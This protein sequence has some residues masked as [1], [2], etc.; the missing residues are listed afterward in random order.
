MDPQ[1]HH[2]RLGPGGPDRRALRRPR[3]P[4]AAAHRRRRGR[5]SA[6]ADDAGRELPGLSRRHHGPGSDGRD[7][8]AGGE[9]RRRDHPGQRHERRPLR[10]AD[11]RQ[12][13]RGRVHGADADHR[14]RRVGAAARP[15]VG[16]DADGPRR[17]DLRDLRRLLLPRPGDRGRRRR[18][19]GDGRGG[20]PHALR[21]EGHAWCTAATR[22]ARRRSCRT[23]RA[24]TRRS[25][26]CSTTRSTRSRT[27]A[28]AK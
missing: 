23:R 13:R 1:R 19:L 14:D 4:A 5:R 22:C 27:P 24:R 26:G 21:D 15:A 20:V 3:Q 16:A 11:R 9:V 18:R 12:D 6:D 7:A 28:R 8:R 2:H 17:L 10:R 25:R